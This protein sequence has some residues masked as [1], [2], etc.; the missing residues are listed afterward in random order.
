MV[1]LRKS[2][3]PPGWYPRD[4]G[5]IGDFLEQCA[6]SD[7]LTA[8]KQSGGV[9][10]R[11]IAAVAPHAGW[12]YSGSIAALAVA[13]LSAGFT[14]SAQ[15]DTVAVIGGHL[16]EGMPALF[17]PEDAVD[18]PLGAMEIDSSL[19]SSLLSGLRELDGFRAGE[20][21]YEDN[22]VEVLLPMVKYF[23]P[24]AKLIWLRL[25]ADNRSFEAGSI[26]ARTAAS[27]GKN[28]A[29]LGS[30]DLT[31]Y[32]AN[33]RFSPR[34][35]GKEA[36]EWVQTV[37]DRRFIETVETGDP[38]AVKER[39]EKEHSACSAG[40][41]LGVMGY[42]AAVRAE[43]GN[44]ADGKTVGSSG[45]LLAYGTSADISIKEDG[46]IPDSFVGYGAFVWDG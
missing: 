19:R 22:T 2:S 42:A 38:A 7:D 40:A 25:P 36:L 27:G 45:K 34:G 14:A 43:R 37:N 6:L 5:K 35:Y 24:Q 23:F 1:S 11:I 16:P 29:V 21:R 10:R 4:P 3:L 17:A 31:H 12:Y 41:V 32:G 8:Y 46:T 30:T 44:T 26:L 39:A 18:T 13:A 28:L 33:Y 20:D 9:P 15:P